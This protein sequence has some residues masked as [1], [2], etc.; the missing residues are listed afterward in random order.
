M[1]SP[2][3]PGLNERLRQL[4][5]TLAVEPSAGL[6]E[7]IARRGRRRRWRRR[8][9][10][11]AAVAAMLAAAL[12]LRAAVLDHTPTPVLDPGPFIQDATAQQLAAGQWQPLPAGPIAGRSGAAVAWTGRQL[13]VWGGS[14][15]KFVK[16][17][18]TGAAY[19]PRTG[20][21]QPLPPAPEGQTLLGSDWQR[22]VWT[23]RELLI[24]GG[25]TPVDP[26][27]RPRLFKPAGALAYDPARRAWRRLPPSPIPPQQLSSPLFW[28]GRELLILGATWELATAGGGL[29][30]VAYD[31]GANRWRRLAPSPQSP[32]LADRH[33]L[34]RTTVWTGSRLLVFNYWSRSARDPGIVSQTGMTVEP[35]GCEVWAYDP[36]ADRWTTL[37]SPSSQVRAL[38][39]R[40][41]LVWDGR[42]VVAVANGNGI[43]P[44]EPRPFAGRYD[45]DRA[46]WTPIGMPRQPAASL[47]WTGGALV[48]DNSDAYDPETDR[49]LRLPKPPKAAGAQ[50]GWVGRE[51]VILR[52]DSPDSGM[53]YVL[54]PAK[55]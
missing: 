54:V 53:I 24:W 10:E 42:D 28:T 35:D 43:V 45:P 51:Q 38:L 4:P 39:A 22:S 13:I 18:N 34:D 37:P 55:R 6:A 16:A 19:D 3:L 48:A 26:Q 21:W 20:G 14:D 2:D 30:G 31:P 29:Q 33:L 32:Q 27:R 15:N 7:R 11:M 8:A 12:A 41:S 25:Y 50:Q 9:G 40:A 52:W 47:T 44:P 17:F 5:A 46:R 23:G 1:P 36:A 49:W